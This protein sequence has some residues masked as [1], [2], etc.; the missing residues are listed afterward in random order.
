V[1]PLPFPLALSGSTLHVPRGDG[2]YVI[3]ID[4]GPRGLAVRTLATLPS[5]E[6][7][8]FELTGIEVRLRLVDDESGDAIE[9]LALSLEGARG[10]I[11][12]NAEDGTYVF[13]PVD[14]GTIGVVHDPECRVDVRVDPLEAENGVLRRE[15]RVRGFPRGVAPE[16]K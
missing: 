12:W 6:P 11:L 5:A 4:G 14:P 3:Q 1:E 16:S 15:L 9:A 8:R 10:A 7:I 13:G 2:P